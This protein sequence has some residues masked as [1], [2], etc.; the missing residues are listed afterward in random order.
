MRLWRGLESDVSVGRLGLR[1]HFLRYL[2]P[3]MR[4]QRGLSAMIQGEDWLCELIFCLL[5]VP[6]RDFSDV[7][8]A[9]IQG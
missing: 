2:S 3:K 4:L 1:T 9:M 6:K 7:K 5:T 8:K